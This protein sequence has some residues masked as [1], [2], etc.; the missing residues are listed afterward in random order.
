MRLCYQYHKLYHRNMFR[1][2]RPLHQYLLTT[3]TGSC[4]AAPT[5]LPKEMEL[6]KTTFGVPHSRSLREVTPRSEYSVHRNTSVGDASHWVAPP[7]TDDHE[8]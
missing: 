1:S 4:W 6:S 7:K 3:K 5:N 8:R 2:K